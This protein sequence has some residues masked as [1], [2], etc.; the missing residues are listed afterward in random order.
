MYVLLI[1]VLEITNPDTEML[2]IDCGEDII[3]SNGLSDGLQVWELEAVVVWSDGQL[4]NWSGF[5]K[6][7][8]SWFHYRDQWWLRDMHEQI[9]AG[10]VDIPLIGT[11][12]MV[13]MVKPQYGVNKTGVKN[14]IHKLFELV[15][16]EEGCPC[17]PIVTAVPVHSPDKMMNASKR[18]SGCSCPSGYA[19]E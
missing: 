8:T 10:M 16:Q 2:I 1:I 3:H 13:V 14:W 6:W 5:R 11:E 18:Y 17:L 9:R 19:D 15:V 12:L 4:D 7:N